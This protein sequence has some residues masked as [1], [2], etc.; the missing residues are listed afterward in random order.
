M[1]RFP[2]S[3]QAATATYVISVRAVRFLLLSNSKNLVQVQLVTAWRNRLQL[4]VAC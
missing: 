1:W 3:Y 4:Q 2:L